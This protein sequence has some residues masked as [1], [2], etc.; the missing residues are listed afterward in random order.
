MPINQI[1]PQLERLR[2]H[3]EAASKTYDY[4]S[5][6]DLSHS[7]RIW[8]DLK[9]ILP[10]IV[11]SFE[12]TLSFKTASPPKKI[13]N[14]IRGCQYVL[15]YMPG[16]VVTSANKGNIFSVPRIGCEMYCGVRVRNVGTHKAE[17][18][19]FYVVAKDLNASMIKVLSNETVTRCNY[20]QWLASDAV[21]MC[22]INSS[23][24]MTPVALSRE[25][26]IKRVANTLNGSHPKLSVTSDSDNKFDEPI[27]YLLQFEWGGLPLPY[28]ILLKIAQDILHVALK[29]F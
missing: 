7:L 19:H 5:L 13:L 9:Q 14:H 10:N 27:H 16:F 1:L 11:P 23:Q 21:R 8:V 3:Y 17:M 2:R 25:I 29:I 24:K 26:L 15:A 12:S 4:V 18:A 20:V 28:F 6:L 22:Y